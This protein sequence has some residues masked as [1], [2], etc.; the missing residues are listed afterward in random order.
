[1]ISDTFHTFHTFP[2]R[3]GIGL[4]AVAPPKPPKAATGGPTA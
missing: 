1:M 4:G 2:L 3:G